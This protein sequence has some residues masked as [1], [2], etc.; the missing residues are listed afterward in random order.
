[1]NFHS[2]F[3]RGIFRG[4]APEGP[5]DL[6]KLKDYGVM[7]V[8]CLETGNFEDGDMFNESAWVQDVDM[9]FWALPIGRF[10]PPSKRQVERA[11]FVLCYA[12]VFVHCKQGVDRTGFIIAKYRMSRGWPKERAVSEF[13]RMGRHW[14][15]FWWEWF[16]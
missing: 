1:M 15:Y 8:L 16:L 10:L 2:I 6:M 4:Q 11:L 13:R 3:H 5:L 9:R 7:H 14:W 12:N